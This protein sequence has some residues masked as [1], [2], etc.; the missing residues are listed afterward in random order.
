MALR[1]AMEKFSTLFATLYLIP[2]QAILGLL[3]IFMMI[4]FTW[5]HHAQALHGNLPKFRPLP[6]LDT[7]RAA[8]RRGAET[9]RAIHLSPGAGSIGQP[10]AMAQTMAGILAAARVIEET[11]LKGTPVL[12]TSGDAVAHLAL[13][14]ALRQAYQHAGQAQDYAPASVRLL[15]LEAPTA[16]A[17]GLMTTYSPQRFE[18]SQ[19]IGP[20][21][22]EFILAGEEAAQYSIPQLVGTTSVSALP[23]LFLVSPSVL[24]G[25]EI[26]ATEAYLTASST[27]QARLLTQDALRLTLSLLVVGG[28]LFQSLVALQPMLPFTLPFL[29]P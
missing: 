25:E 16:Y 27:P 20:L 9:G 4:G 2:A 7:L 12:V 23:L 29:V 24:I 26:F 1:P 15:A 19:I 3:I 8:L 13:K 5:L 14:G 17:M 21:G 11:A 10:P 28:L 22:P 6:A 18:A